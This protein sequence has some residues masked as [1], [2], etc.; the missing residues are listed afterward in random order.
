MNLRPRRREPL[1]L[2]LTPLIDVV[3]LLLIFFMV[4]TTFR[5][6]SEFDI[7]LPEASQT[8]TE[9]SDQLTVHVD[10]GGRYRVNEQP[11]PGTSVAALRAYLEA[12]MES[13]EITVLTIRADADTP[14]QAVVRVM[15]AAGQAGLQRIAIATTQ[16]GQ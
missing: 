3:F 16:G 7:T 5:Q 13:G 2:G 15:D 8:P 1:E 10:A 12:A 14:H 11:L 9:Q 4:T 6:E